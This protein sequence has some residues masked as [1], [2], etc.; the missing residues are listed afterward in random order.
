MYDM[1]NAKH[2]STPVKVRVGRM[3]I[4]F[5]PFNLYL[6]NNDYKG[7]P[8][9][10]E[11]QT[12]LVNWY[13][14]DNIE[15]ELL[16][17]NATLYYSCSKLNKVFSEHSYA[18]NKLVCSNFLVNF[19]WIGNWACRVCRKWWS[20]LRHMPVNLYI[21]TY[22]GGVVSRYFSGRKKTPILTYFSSSRKCIRK[23]EFS[24]FLRTQSM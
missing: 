10:N 22:Y 24:D 18:R 13:I 6:V 1:L 16:Q 5:K 15:R 11:I 2:S 4:I 14:A 20:F 23:N 19:H 7:C 21:M 8:F 3:I 9:S 17:F 12:P